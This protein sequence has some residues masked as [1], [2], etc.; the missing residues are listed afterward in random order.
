MYNAII[1]DDEKNIREG[2]V[3]LIDWEELGIHVCAAVSNGEQVLKYIEQN[4]NEVDLVVTDIKMPVMDGMELA[5]VLYERHPEIMIVILTAY[6][7]FKYAQQAIKYRV[8]DFVIKNDFFVELPKAVEQIVKKWEEDGSKTGKSENL[9]EHGELC[10]VCVCEVVGWAY[11]D[12]E[13]CKKGLEELAKNIFSNHKLEILVEDDG[14]LILIVQYQGKMEDIQWMRRKL[15]KLISLAK[16]FQNIQLRIGGGGPIKSSE[17]MSKGKNQAIRNLSDIYT[18]EQPVNVREESVEYIHCWK[19]DCDIDSYMRSLYIALRSGGQE[20]WNKHHTEFIEYLRKENR[21]VE[22]CRS[23]TYAI[24]SYLLRKIRNLVNEEKILTPES[25]LNEVYKSKT[26]ASLADVMKETCSVI[27]SLFSEE[28]CRV[29]RLVREADYIIERSYQEKLS[30]KSISQELFV[31]SSYLS[32]VYK[33]DTGITVTDAI[34]SYRIKKAKEM[35]ETGEYKIYEVGK[36]V[37]IE[38]PAY[39]THVFLKYAG[40]SPTDYMNKIEM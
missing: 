10:R 32:R 33:K 29:R 25:V 30:L 6:S 7:D 8:A 18:D 35:L 9:F 27:A 5:Q 17:C 22:Q 23:D 14:Y 20:E 15:E 11:R 34:N 24:I 26:K 4:E 19:D 40:E 21:S 16:T 31:N 13:S 28:S 3:E 38:D 39:F 1:A 37:G 2:I 12:L 36:L